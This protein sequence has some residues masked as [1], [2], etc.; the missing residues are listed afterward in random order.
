[1]AIGVGAEVGQRD[2]LVELPLLADAAGVAVLSGCDG[3]GEAIDVAGALGGPS[4]ARSGSSRRGTGARPGRS[5]FFRSRL[6][7][8]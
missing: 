8:A 3:D 6:R 2:A 7:T 1:M 4:P 5:F